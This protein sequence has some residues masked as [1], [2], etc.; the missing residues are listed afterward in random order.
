MHDGLVTE[1]FVL[2]A[3]CYCIFDMIKWTICEEK[4]RLGYISLEVMEL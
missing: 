4:N 1:N 3:S 2:L